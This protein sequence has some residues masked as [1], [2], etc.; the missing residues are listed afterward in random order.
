M[1]EPLT[2]EDRKLLE[3]RIHAM[4]VS[5]YPSDRLAA[6]EIRTLRGKV[7]KLADRLA[8]KIV[9]VFGGSLETENTNLRRT[10]K[11]QEL[12]KKGTAIVS[13]ELAEENAKLREGLRKYGVHYASCPHTMHNIVPEHVPEGTP[14]DCGLDA[15]L[16][17]ADDAETEVDNKLQDEKDS[18]HHS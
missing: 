12:G 3:I 7:D 2:H 5:P 1:N 18:F 17:G 13:A 11:L 15:A 8:D 16:K 14:C 9:D 6:A 4:A 10:I